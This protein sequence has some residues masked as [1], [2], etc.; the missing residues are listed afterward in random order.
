MTDA[1]STP[2]L[3]T[4]EVFAFIFLGPVS[5]CFG[6]IRLGFPSWFFY[7]IGSMAKEI[8]FLATISAL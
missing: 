6:L 2:P 4:S 5:P 1:A 3:K 8:P 7:T